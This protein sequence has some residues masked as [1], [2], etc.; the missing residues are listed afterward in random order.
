PT[1][2][3]PRRNTTSSSR[4]VRTATSSSSCPAR[5]R[6]ARRPRGLDA[7][8]GRSG[9]GTDVTFLSPS[10]LF[11]ALSGLLPLAAF[12]FQQWRA[13]RAAI[14]IGEPPP[15]LLPAAFDAFALA[16]VPTLLAL[17]IA[18]PVHERAKSRIERRGVEAYVVLDISGSMAAS[19]SAVSAT[20]LE[21][22]AG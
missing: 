11:F 12:A 6:P 19:T 22:A 1:R 17:A 5:D 18:Q 20:R 8:P 7:A 21:R 13:R 2:R 4:C 16:A 9:A 3:T 15:R 14:E 10:A